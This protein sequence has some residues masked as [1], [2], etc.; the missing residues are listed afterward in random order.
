MMVFLL[1]TNAV[2]AHALA[3]CSPAA[4]GFIPCRHE[5]TRIDAS[6]IV[7]NLV[8]ADL[9]EIYELEQFWALTDYARNL[10]TLITPVWQIIFHQ[11]EALAMSAH[12]SV[13]GHFTQPSKGLFN[14]VYAT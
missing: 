6:F 9:A 13:L 12:R 14:N 5:L 8:T 11:R 3:H 2:A 4:K 10:L 7:V 1:S